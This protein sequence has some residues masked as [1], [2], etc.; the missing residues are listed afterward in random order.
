RY[1]T[2]RHQIALPPP[3]CATRLHSI[4]C[5]PGSR[6]S[7]PCAARLHPLSSLLSSSLFS[8]ARSSA[9]LAF[10]ALAF[11]AAQLLVASTARSSAAL[12]F[13]AAQLLAV[14][15]AR[16]SAALAFVAAQLITVRS[17]RSSA[18]LVFLSRFRCLSPSTTRNPAY[19]PAYCNQR[20][21]CFTLALRTMTPTQLAYVLPTA[22]P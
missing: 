10:A 1:R 8:T 7:A 12:A 3:L 2:Y 15:T 11:I 22:V 21:D 19:R 14:S 17:A 16:S 6:C 4:R 5:C 13:A 9:A 20:L 18:A